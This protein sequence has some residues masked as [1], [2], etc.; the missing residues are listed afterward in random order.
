RATAAGISQGCVDDL[1]AR[2][3]DCERPAGGLLIAAGAG[4]LTASRPSSTLPRRWTAPNRSSPTVA[5][6]WRPA[7]A[8]ASAAGWCCGWA[9]HHF[10]RPGNRFWP[11]LHLSG[12]TPR[13]LHPSQQRRLL[14]LG[15]GVTN[16]VARTTARAD[17]LAPAELAAGG[18]ALRAKLER[19]RPRWLAVLGAGAY[20]TAFKRPAA[21]VG[22]QPD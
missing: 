21:T 22:E 3:S 7:S 12:F 20:R 14:E 13:L 10:G 5:A 2:R 4:P 18:L 1:V 15:L 17:E 11:A 16:L 6:R 19:H 8:P 9:G